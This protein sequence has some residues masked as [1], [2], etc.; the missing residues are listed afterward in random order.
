MKTVKPG[1]YFWQGN[2]ACAEAAILAGCR[3]FA[4]YPITPASEIAENLAKRLPQVGGLAI[5]MEDEI[6]SLG[7]VIGASWAG[8]KSMTATSGPGFSLM[9]ESIGYAFM[10]ETPCVIVDV[11]RSGPS[12]G[13]ATKC[14]QGDVM[15]AR[16]G[17]HGD[18]TAIALSPNSPQE[19]FNF[20]IRA[21]N[22]AEKY[23]TPV[24]LLTDEVTAHMR[25]KVVVPPL[26]E[27]EIVNRKR[28]MAGEKAFFGLSEVPPMPFVGEGFNVAVTGSTHDHQGIRFTADAN[29]HKLLVE[30][31]NRKILSRIEEISDVETYNIGENCQVG[32]VSYGCTARAVYEAAE[33]SEALGLKVGYVRLKT[34]WPFPEKTIKKFAEKTSK[35]IVPEMNLR[36]IYYEVERAVKD[37]ARVVSLNK[38]GGELITP[39]EIL[40][41]ILQEEANDE[42]C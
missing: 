20:T 1:V 14:A 29:V 34:V 35:I 10:T 33:N 31:L 3:F 2:E 5:Q 15:Q 36:Q 4:G 17:T 41:K 26:A 9:Q 11:Q 32:L 7:A 13:Q 24:I 38:I 37:M 18:Y 22:L 16:W 25:E 21:F 12:T 23:R 40:Q 28:P 27:I 30:R 8:A 19:M 6:A 39:E 42:N